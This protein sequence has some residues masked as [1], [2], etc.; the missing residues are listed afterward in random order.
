MSALTILSSPGPLPV[1]ATFEAPT[2]GPVTLL[3]T[4]SA[5]SATAGQSVGVSVLFDRSSPGTSTACCTSANSHQTLVPAMLPA[6]IPG[7]GTQKIVLVAA[8]PQTQSDAND[9]YQVTLLY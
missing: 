9:F 6:T 8:T 5:Y 4:G 7:K 1:T 3:V 2:D